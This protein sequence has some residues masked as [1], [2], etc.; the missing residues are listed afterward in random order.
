MMRPPWKRW[1]LRALPAYWMFLFCVTHFPRLELYGPVPASDKVIHFGAFGLLAFLFWRFAEAIHGHL[2]HRFVWISA[3]VLLAYATVDEWLQ[4]YVGR[5]TELVD[6][7][8]DMA[9]VTFTLVALESRRRLVSARRGPR[10]QAA[11]ESAS[12]G[13]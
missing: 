3:G 12:T 4:Q 6:W 8:A 5:G 13:R 2:S 1:Y 7:L 10:G 9:G 11:L